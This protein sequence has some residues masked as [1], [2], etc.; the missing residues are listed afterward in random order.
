MLIL[1]NCVNPFK[2]LGCLLSEL[3]GAFSIQ[4]RGGFIS[5]QTGDMCKKPETEGRESR[6]S[7]KNGGTRKWKIKKLVAHVVCEC[8]SM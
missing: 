1:L 6:E 5:R 3:G 7:R 4:F 2:L 8:R